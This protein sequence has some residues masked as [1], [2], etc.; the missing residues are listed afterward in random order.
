MK[1]KKKKPFDKH[2]F[3]LPPVASCE[4]GVAAG[5]AAHAGR[6]RASRPPLRAVGRPGQAPLSP[7]GV[8]AGPAPGCSPKPRPGACTARALNRSARGLA[9]GRGLQTVLLCP[10]LPSALSHRWPLLQPQRD[11][12][13]PGR[14]GG[15]GRAMRRESGNRVLGHEPHG[16]GRS[17]LLSGLGLP[18]GTERQ[19]Q[20]SSDR[21]GSGVW[22]VSAWRTGRS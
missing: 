1:I 15:G 6:S 22:R 5:P 10:H 13:A 9:R 19:L 4:R 14:A 18:V 17:R 21:G 7:G 20:V 11:G 8:R 16:L 12:V 3:C 2:G